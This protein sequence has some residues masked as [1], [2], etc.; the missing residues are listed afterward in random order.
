VIVFEVAKLVRCQ[1][2]GDPVI[3][4]GPKV[5]ANGRSF[6][7]EVCVAIDMAITPGVWI[8]ASELAPGGYLHNR[9]E[10]WFEP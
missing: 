7:S 10:L 6:C 3:Y 9:P 4:L 1:V 5:L 2:C 8:D